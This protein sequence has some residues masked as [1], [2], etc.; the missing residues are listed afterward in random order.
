MH[1]DPD[2]LSVSRRYQ[3]MI[4]LIVP[5]PIAFVSTRGS[6]GRTNLAPFSYFMG[7]ASDPPLLAIS[8][9]ARAGTLKDTARNILDTVEFVVTAA[10]ETIAEAVNRAS[11]DWPPDTDEFALTGLTPAPSERVA[12]PR[13][14]ESPFSLE[15][16]V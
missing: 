11:G 12:P 10:T 7:V 3:L 5:R 13:V 2:S 1:F 8:V 6:D 15:C 16:R 14:A 4:S 9:S